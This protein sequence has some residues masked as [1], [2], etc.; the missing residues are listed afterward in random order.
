VAK[1][2]LTRRLD[3]ADRVRELGD[4]SVPVFDTHAIIY[5]D[6]APAAKAGAT[7]DVEAAVAR[8]APDSPF[9]RDV[10]AQDYQET[11]ARRNAALLALD[12]VHDTRLPEA[13]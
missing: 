6:D 2:G 12:A 8:L 9:F 1:I 10:E 5:S 4:A 11:L 13:I 3:P 7:Q